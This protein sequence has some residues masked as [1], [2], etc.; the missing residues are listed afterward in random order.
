VKLLFIGDVMGAPGQRVLA[1]SL[2]ALRKEM[3]AD[4]VVCNA[5]NVAQGC[6]V[7][8][9]GVRELLAAGVDVMTNGN[10][11]W[12]KREA[13]TFIGTEPRLMRPFNYPPGT[14]GTGWSVFTTPSGHRVGVLNLLGLVFMHPH[15]SCPF[16]A[17][18]AALAKKPAD[19]K[20]V[21]IDFHAEATSEKYALGWHVDGR[22]SALVGTHTHVPTA[23]ERVLPGGTAYISDVGMTGTY[24]SVI[25]LDTKKALRRFIQKMPERFD[26]AEGRATLCGVIIDIDETTGKSRSIRRVAVSED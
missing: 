23:D 2:P 24:D 13:A 22:V 1:A 11:A 10:H 17:A 21:L 8:G 7:N 5:E 4:L 25:G 19:V 16:S 12:D 14:P 9:A 20:I 15:L 3:E 26:P 18:D 6:G